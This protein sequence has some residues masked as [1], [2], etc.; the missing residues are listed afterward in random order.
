[1]AISPLLK[2]IQIQRIIRLAIFYNFATILQLMNLRAT[3]KRLISAFLIALYAFIVT[4]TQWWHHHEIILQAASTPIAKKTGPF[5]I[6]DNATANTC[7]IC[8]H[9]YSFF[10]KD[11]AIPKISTPIFWATETSKLTCTQ[12]TEPNRSTSGRAPPTALG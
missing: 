2:I 9:H 4:P 1:M 5:S 10:D 6:V 7:K 8:S 11:A 3:H 12:Y